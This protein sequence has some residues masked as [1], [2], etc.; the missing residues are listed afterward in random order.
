MYEPLISIITI[1]YN[2]FEATLEFLR[3]VKSTKYSKKEV[4]VVDNA[5]D[6][7]DQKQI[8]ATMPEVKILRNKSNLGFAEGNAIGVSVASGDVYAFLNNDLE[9][10][11]D[12]FEPILDVFF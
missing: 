11:V 5:S 7:F 6:Y 2:S 4:I 8:L 12:F 3:S 10:D 1:N 9:I